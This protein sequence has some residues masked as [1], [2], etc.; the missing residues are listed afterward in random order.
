MGSV[1]KTDTKEWMTRPDWILL[2]PSCAL[3][4]HVSS[5]LYTDKMLRNPA[6]WTGFV[7]QG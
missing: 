2:T 6:S 4:E 5:L 1:K 3:D 7:Q